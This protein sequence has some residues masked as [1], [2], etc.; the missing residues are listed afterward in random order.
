MAY[1]PIQQNQYGYDKPPPYNPQHQVPG[2]YPPP[3]PGYHPAPY[4]GYQQQGYAP[5]P[6]TTATT[7]VVVVGTT[8]PV[9]HIT[10]VIL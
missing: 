7:N 2:A 1:Q 9:R 5:H 3:Q 4:Q 8:Q 6:G 10:R